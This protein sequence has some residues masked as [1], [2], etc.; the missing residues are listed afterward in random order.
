[1]KN[2]ALVLILGFG[3]IQFV[4]PLHAAESKNTKGSAKKAH[5]HKK[6]EKHSKCEACGKDEKDC[7]CDDKKDSHSEGDGHTH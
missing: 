3:I 7:K 5:V 2:R 6:G 1:M 4:A